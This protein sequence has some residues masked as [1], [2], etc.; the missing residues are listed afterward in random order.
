MDPVAKYVRIH[1]TLPPKQG[2]G[3]AAKKHHNTPK[4]NRQN[5]EKP[6]KRTTPLEDA[7][8]AKNHPATHFPRAEK[9]PP[10]ERKY[11]EALPSISPPR[12]AEKGSKCCP[13]SGVDFVARTYGVVVFFG[14][15]CGRVH[16]TDVGWRL[17]AA[18]LC[19]ASTEVGV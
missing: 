13:K 18:A 15:G 19:R 8:F 11:N 12:T 7:T 1:L 17:L 3:F 5:T 2:R 10:L 4:K 14:G 16:G 6:P 9:N